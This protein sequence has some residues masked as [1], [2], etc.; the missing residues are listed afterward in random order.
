M[1]TAP[2]STTVSG[3]PIT[4]LV[5][6]TLINEYF[7]F[8]RIF[9]NFQR[10][11]FYLTHYFNVNDAE[12]N[13]FCTV[14]TQLQTSVLNEYQ[15]HRQQQTPGSVLTTF[16][17]VNK[18]ILQIACEHGFPSLLEFLEDCL[19]IRTETSTN[20]QLLF[21]NKVMIF[22]SI[23]TTSNRESIPSNSSITIHS[24]QSLDNNLLFSP[25]GR[26]FPALVHRLFTLHLGINDCTGKEISTITFTGIVRHEE[27]STLLAFTKL[28]YPYVH[29][30]KTA[31]ESIVK[32]KQIQQKQF[33]QNF[34]RNYSLEDILGDV[35]PY[36]DEEIKLYNNTVESSFTESTKLFLSK[37][38]SVRKMY[39]MIRVLLWGPAQQQNI[40]RLLFGLA[41]DKKTAPCI[42][43]TI[44][45]NK[46]SHT[47]RIK[48]R[49][50]NN[51]IEEDIS[52]I[53][54]TRLSD[55]DIRKLVIAHQTM[56]SRVRAAILDKTEEMKVHS[57]EYHK[58]LTYV[59]TLLYFP[60]P[61]KCQSIIASQDSDKAG[62]LKMI[63][64]KLDSVV[65][66]HQ[67]TKHCLL[68]SVAKWLTNPYGKGMILGMAG[69]PG[70]GK[71][72]LARS[73]GDA[74]G[75]P[76]VQITLGGQN[77]GE[78]LH[79]HGYTYSGSTPGLIIK[80]MVEAGKSRCI[81]YFDELDKSSSKNGDINEIMSI[82]IH[83][84]DTTTQHRFQDRFFQGIEFP[85]HEVIFIF[86]YNDPSRVDPIL[87]DRLTQ[88]EV[89]AFSTDEKISISHNFLIPAIT[90]E[91]SFKNDCL[92]LTKEVLEYTIHKYTCEAG[93]RELKRVLELVFET[94]N[95][96]YL[97]QPEI[98]LNKIQI[99]KEYVD[100]IVEATGQGNRHTYAVN[101]AI[102]GSTSVGIVNGLFANPVLGFGGVT[103]LQVVAKPITNKSADPV[104]FTGTQGNTMKESALCALTSVTNYLLTYGQTKYN[105]PK[106]VTNTVREYF[107]YGFHVHALDG[108]T[109]KDGPS[110]GIV[111]AMC[112]FSVITNIPIPSD[113]AMTGEVDVKGNI[114]CVGGVPAK[115][116]GAQRLNIRTVFIS[117]ENEIEVKQW[118]TKHPYVSMDIVLVGSIS[119]VAE[120]IFS[121]TGSS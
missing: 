71:T 68:L 82:L 61:G 50:L 47:S 85:M 115:L 6:V 24:L 45:Y 25:T 52:K 21:Y 11:A 40:A 117:K 104:V 30:L 18:K 106:P 105:M 26:V 27:T 91:L 16:D 118:R 20:E 113:V 51:Q 99:S 78:L 55:I 89:A 5:T 13:N 96:R 28:S 39:Q 57:N 80:K 87:M 8:T 97:L 114:H 60:W 111:F 79:G 83:L 69:P 1:E 65:Y 75:I 58:Q 41:K 72:M 3:G 56:P 102:T 35:S 93:V 67:Q 81:M 73:L 84:T 88:V 46:L 31:F 59:Q 15:H 9:E 108:H 10:H 119:E 120:I 53:K 22:S 33:R 64:A 100:Q 12:K 32:G 112:F 19:G 90:K 43:S 34:L 110:A 14:I 77:D 116:S 98:D 48:L 54:S 49:H 70:V 86:S 42:I 66:G 44:I 17:E 63:Q 103:T 29:Q 7:R 37:E 94:I 23:Q 38:T 62:H 107:P 76:F 74:L 101:A 4:E 92:Y 95:F 2:M 121:K 36:V 109:A